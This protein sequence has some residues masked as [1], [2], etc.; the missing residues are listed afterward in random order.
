MGWVGFD[1]NLM[2]ILEVSKDI[3]QKPDYQQKNRNPTYPR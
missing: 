3:T 1:W 2:E